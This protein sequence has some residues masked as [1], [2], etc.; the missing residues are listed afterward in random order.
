MDACK[1]WYKTD[2]GT[3]DRISALWPG[4]LLHQMETIRA[5][6]W[7]DYDLETKSQNRLRWLGNGLS[8]CLTGG[9]DPSYYLN[10]DV[11]DVPPSGT[12]EKDPIYEA[13][14]Y[15]H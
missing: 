2:G 14:P 7:E 6:R 3:G 4:S 5:P 15:S 13:R 12:P 11:V 8:I 9:G 10:P 1:S